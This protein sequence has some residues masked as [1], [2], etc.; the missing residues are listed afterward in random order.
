MTKDKT[1]VCEVL[2]MEPISEM[3]NL[4]E[5][6]ANAVKRIE[7]L[8]EKAKEHIREMAIIKNVKDE[9]QYRPIF[10]EGRVLP[11]GDDVSLVIDML[12]QTYSLSKGDIARLIGV[13]PRSNNTINRW[14][15]SGEKSTIP[16][17]AYRLLC[18]YAGLS[19]DLKLPDNIQ[20]KQIDKGA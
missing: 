8:T 15:K 14:L 12:M 19:V 2:D 6:T 4:L 5:V 11:T 10:L 9:P 20:A 7:I 13:S 3:D 17:A 16:Y 1:N 18:A